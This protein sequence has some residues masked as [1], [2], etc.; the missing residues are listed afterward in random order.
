MT[1]FVAADNVARQF[2]LTIANCDR[3]T[4][5]KSVRYRVLGKEKML[6]LLG[7][8]ADVTVAAEPTIMQVTEVESDAAK[9]NSKRVGKSGK[10]RMH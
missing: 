6:G 2:G 5:H 9:S 4:V 10:A 1:H 7:D 3:R 8:T